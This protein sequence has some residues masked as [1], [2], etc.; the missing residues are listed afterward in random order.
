MLVA[1]DRLETEIRSRP[2]VLLIHGTA[3]DVVPFGALAQA[4]TALKS[5]SVPVETHISP[6]IGHSV[7]MDGLTA[8]ASFARRVLA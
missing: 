2:P 8:A 4:E 7:G 6:G 5:A 1:P 3:D